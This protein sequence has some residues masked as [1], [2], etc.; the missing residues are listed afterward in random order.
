MR[1]ET[2]SQNTNKQRT[3][4]SS[5]NYS[6][7]PMLRLIPRDKENTTSKTHTYFFASCVSQIISNLSNTGALPLLFFL[8]FSLHCLCDGWQIWLFSGNVF[9]VRLQQLHGT[10]HSH[11]SPSCKMNKININSCWSLNFFKISLLTITYMK[12]PLHEKK[13][14]KK[15]EVLLSRKCMHTYIS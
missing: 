4:N 10:K 11:S 1:L 5:F 3:K 12:I 15:K 9:D 7:P 8:F 13:E 6:L 2:A 14:T